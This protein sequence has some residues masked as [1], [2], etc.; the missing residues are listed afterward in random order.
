MTH[1]T[2]VVVEFDES[3]RS[4]EQLIRRFMRKCKDEGILKEHLEQFRHETKGQKRRRKEREG[5]RRQQKKQKGRV[6]RDRNDQ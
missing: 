2:N 4:F 1:P 3:V 5:K 6:T